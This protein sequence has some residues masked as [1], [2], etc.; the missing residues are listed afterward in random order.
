M[1]VVDKISQVELQKST[2][3]DGTETTTTKPV[4][5]P[6]IKNIFLLHF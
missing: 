4:T 3:S 5:A 1:D 6:V 2:G